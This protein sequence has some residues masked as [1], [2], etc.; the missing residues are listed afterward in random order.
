MGLTRA[1]KE[2]VQERAQKD[3]VFRRSLLE[4][5]LNEFLAG[6][7][8]TAKLLLRDYINAGPS[9]ERISKITKI[10]DKSLQR[11]LSEH[12]NP[13]T[14]NFCALL[15]AIQEVEDVHLGIKIRR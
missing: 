5:A 15:Q 9:F 10:K 4:E 2:L 13:T 3:S 8:R 6:D 12:G 1:F 7:L 14:S 11:M